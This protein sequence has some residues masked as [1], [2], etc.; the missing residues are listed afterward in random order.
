[1]SDPLLGWVPRPGARARHVSEGN[2]D[3][4]QVIDAKGRRAIPPNPGARRTLYFFGDLFTFGHGVENDQTA[5]SIIARALGARANVV[6][7]GVKAYGLE[8][9]FLRLRAAKDDIQ[10]GDVVSFRPYPWTSRAT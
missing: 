1:M 3:V 4:I 6:N 9:M 5:L 10:P 7:Y 8:Q 2:F